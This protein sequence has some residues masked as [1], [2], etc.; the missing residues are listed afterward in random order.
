MDEKTQKHLDSVQAELIRREQQHEKGNKLLRFIR[1]TVRA[2]FTVTALMAFLTGAWFLIQFF[3]LNADLIEGQIK[4]RLIPSLTGGKF[5]LM[6]SKISGDLYQGVDLEGVSILN[7]SFKS[8]GVFLTVPNIS[9]NYSLWDVFL[10]QLILEKVVIKNPV[11]SLSRNDEGKGI[12]DFSQTTSETSQNASGTPSLTSDEQ[13]ARAEKLADSYLR[14]F[15]IKNLSIIV[16]E[17]RE[18]LVDRF[19]SNALKIP[20]STYQIDGINLL[21]RKFPKP[22]FTDH[23]LKLDLPQFPQLATLQF[24]RIRSTGDTNLIVDIL[25]RNLILS[26]QNR[27]SEGRFIRIFDGKKK[28]SLNLSFFWGRQSVNILKR[29]SGLN[30]T[31]SFDEFDVINQFLPAGNFAS[32]S[33]YFE[34][35]SSDAHEPLLETVIKGSVASATV[36]I[37][38]TLLLENLSG[39][40]ALKNRIAQL[41]EIKARIS[42]IPAVASGQ[43]DFKDL[44]NLAAIIQADFSGEKIHLSAKRHRINPENQNVDLNLDRETGQLHLSFL[45]S[46]ETGKNLLK[47]I[48]F[49][50]KLCSDKPL[51]SL[52]PL[53]ILP[54]EKSKKLEDWFEKIDVLGPLNIQGMVND[55][56]NLKEASASLFLEGA[57]L[58]SKSKLTDPVFLSGKANLL[59]ELLTLEDIG[60]KI[61]NLSFSIDGEA[62]FSA[63][64]KSLQDYKFKLSGQLLPSDATK[65]PSQNSSQNN[66]LKKAGSASLNPSKGITL[67]EITLR[68]S[69]GLEKPLPF[70]SVQIEGREFLN[71]NLDSKQNL[72]Q[73]ILSADKIKIT[74]K[75]KIW[76]LESIQ[77]VFKTPDRLFEKQQKIKKLEALISA[78]FFGIPVCASSTL[79]LAQDQ[80]ENLKISSNGKD[81]QKVLDNLK[82]IEQIDS[83]LKKNSIALSGEYSI[84][85]SGKGKI[86]RPNIEGQ[87]SSPKLNFKSKNIEMTL[88]LSLVLSTNE[89]GSYFGKIKTSTGQIKFQNLLLPIDKL[90]GTVSYGKEK[91]AKEQSLKVSGQSSLM[92]A[93]VKVDSTYIPKSSFLENL[94]V[95]ISTQDIGKLALEA[96]KFAKLNCPFDIS[97]PLNADFSAKG[98]TNVISATGG[99]SF[100]N[101]N[102]KI[103]LKTALNPKY[104]AL[105]NS[106]SGKLKFKET[107]QKH[108]EVETESISGSILGSKISLSGKAQMER[109]DQTFTTQLNG[110]SMNINGLSVAKLKN[111]I[112]N[113]IISNEKLREFTN[114][115]GNLKGSLKVSGSQNRFSAL[116]EIELEKGKTK[117]SAI[118][119]S[120]EEI[121]GKLVFSKHSE[122]EKPFIELKE[123]KSKFGKAQVEI[124]SGKIIDPLGK[125]E[126]AL[127]ASAKSVF[128]N[129]IMSLLS[130][131]KLPKISFDGEGSLNGNFSATGPINAPDLAFNLDGGDFQINYQTDGNTYKLP[132]GKS[133]IKFAFQPLQGKVNC[134]NSK[135]GLLKGYINLTEGE[136]KFT[137]GSPKEFKVAGNFDG[138]NLNAFSTNQG[139]MFK[140]VLAGNFGASA[141][142]S[143]KKDLEI[144]MNFK[145]LCFGKLPLDPTMIDKIGLEF[146]EAPE[147]KE[148]QMNFFLSSEGDVTEKGRLRIAD[149]LFAGPEMRIEIGESAFDPQNLQL[150]GKICLNPQPLR[151]TKL[152][153][154][155]GKLT[156]V[157]QDPKT[158]V[159][160]VDLTVSGKWSQ[161]ELIGK[162]LENK[163]KSRGKRNFIRSI[164]GGNRA[165]K[166]SVEELEQ[167]FPGWQPGM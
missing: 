166:A 75:S 167:W 161:P 15:E 105:F 103:P 78:T 36:K 1:R 131:L 152:G 47:N 119:Q 151:K 6:I 70:E 94:N 159:P 109:I 144:H 86:N 162:T 25:S 38:D 33:F 68:N 110:I 150:T 136:G 61:Q 72:S 82:E 153:Q 129:E 5:P 155:M 10:G 120:I 124:P 121:S 156:K 37:P 77:G 91:G 8:G 126:I 40:F 130:G 85:I 17:P 158:G 50:L 149:A 48:A 14:Y 12:W 35:K 100:T 41:D 24:N 92:Q 20:S 42:G 163:A 7:P 142:V 57:R 44:K 135:I 146:L 71:V 93:T 115:E 19:L 102:I 13:Q 56:K 54:M 62:Q 154:K 111:E 140:G 65:S 66:S 16:P 101:L 9:L 97:G 28:E 84:T 59:G 132:I 112:E 4:G 90:D 128:P 98:P 133:A 99:I 89:T 83:V 80:I 138:I 52:I 134:S 32:G 122:K 3:R 147:F 22:D 95:E 160:Y 145:D 27:G 46:S 96:L 49:E 107:Q 165:H 58:V 139:E 88:P 125:C 73:G 29:I 51:S 45:Q 81:I 79:N 123:F 87:I 26:I 118:P 164:F 116:G 69:L 63:E 43:L 18:I 2:L 143:G 76:L 106:L 117:Y 53:K 60:M 157:L 113:N 137:G 55:P 74:N 30:G 64:K 11:L 67:K 23:I 141:D 108:Y 127:E 148:G 104:Q 114:V 34:A 39:N 31:F 21:L